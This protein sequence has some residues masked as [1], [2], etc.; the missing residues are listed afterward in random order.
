MKTAALL[1]PLTSSFLL[2]ACSRTPAP[3]REQPE[4]VA[5]VVPAEGHGESTEPR[6]GPN[7][8]VPVETAPPNVPEFKPAFPEQTRAPAIHTRTKFVVTEIAQDFDQPWA[9]AF[10]PDGRV[11]VTEKLDESPVG[12]FVMAAQSF[13]AEIE[14]E[15]I[16]E[17]SVRGKKTRIQTG[18]IHGHGSDLF[19]YHRDK[20]AGRRFLVL[21]R[22]LQAEAQK[23]DGHDGTSVNKKS[24]EKPMCSQVS[25]TLGK[26]CLAPTFL[27]G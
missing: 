8:G 14:R 27:G 7:P 2:A 9:I 5:R 3:K 10:L 22:V 24:P 18:K 20:D 26:R 12:R 25:V 16:R 21:G 17:R 4:Q 15:K 19:G 11:L 1:L 13:T 6:V 23:S